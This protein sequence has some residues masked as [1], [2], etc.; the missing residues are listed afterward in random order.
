MTTLFAQRGRLLSAFILLLLATT[1]LYSQDVFATFE[2]PEEVSAI[3]A[4]DGVRIAASKRFPAWNA[5]SLEAIFPPTGGTIEF[6]KIPQDWRRNESLLLFAWG[7][8]PAS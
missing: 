4:S 5:N 2:K 7:L 8:Q 3:K 1:N 6:T